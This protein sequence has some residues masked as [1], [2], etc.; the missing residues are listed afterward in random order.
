MKKMVLMLFLISVLLPARTEALGSIS[1]SLGEGIAIKNK[2]V[3]R[4]PL[5]LEI[6]PSLSYLLLK[7]DLGFVLSVE[8]PA[9]FYLRPGAR[10]CLPWLY[11]RGAMPIKLT[12]GLDVGFLVGVGKNIVSI[13]ILSLFIEV[14]TFFTREWGFST[15]PVEGRIG[16]SLGF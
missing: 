9:D 11:F 5:N 7:F 4:T 1:F 3:S 6:L 15:V 16:V 2:D 14:D 13:K 12:H 10:V 8:A